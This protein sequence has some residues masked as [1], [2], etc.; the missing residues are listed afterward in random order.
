MGWPVEDESLCL[1]FLISLTNQQGGNEW[2]KYFYAIVRSCFV[3]IFQWK[4]TVTIGLNGNWYSNDFIPSRLCP[5]FRKMFFVIFPF[6]STTYWIF[7]F[8]NLLSQCDR[9]RRKYHFEQKKNYRQN[10]IEF[11]TNSTKKKE[12]WIDREVNGIW[13]GGIV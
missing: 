5:C 4:I 10:W 3:L 8:F 11:E 9:W 6:I 12:K 7:M 13:Y 1:V 2:G